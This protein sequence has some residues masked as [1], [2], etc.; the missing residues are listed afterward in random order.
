MFNFKLKWRYQNIKAK[1]FILNP[2]YYFKHTLCMNIYKLN[3]FDIVK[4][5]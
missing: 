4:K 1:E 3:L 5:N 2:I